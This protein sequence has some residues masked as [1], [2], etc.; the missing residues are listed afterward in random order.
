VEDFRIAGNSLGGYDWDGRSGQWWTGSTDAGHWEDINC[1]AHFKSDLD[2]YLSSA[3]TRYRSIQ[4]TLSLILNLTHYPDNP[5]TNRQLNWTQPAW[6]QLAC[7]SA[8]SGQQCVK[9]VDSEVHTG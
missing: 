8:P 1:G 4:V 3:G 5:E 2:W 6:T 9:L 7:A